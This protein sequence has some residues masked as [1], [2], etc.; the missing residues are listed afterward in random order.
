MKPREARLAADQVAR[1]YFLGLS[2]KTAVD[3]VKAGEFP[4]VYSKVTKERGLIR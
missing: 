2:F 4:S 3:V 1:L